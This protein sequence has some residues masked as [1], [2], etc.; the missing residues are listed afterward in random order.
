MPCLM[1][2]LRLGHPRL[3]ML[4]LIVALGSGCTAALPYRAHP[5]LPHRT[6]RIRTVGIV[7]PAISAY[8]E[9]AW[10]K[11]T[12]DDNRS[13]QAER[14]VQT[15][16]GDEMA[17]LNIP[18]VLI[19]GGD[20]DLDDMADLFSAVD[21]TMNLYGY[22]GST[23]GN[24]ESWIEAF[25]GK[26]RFP[27]YALGPAKEAMARHGVDAVWFV[28]GYNLFPTT[29]ARVKDAIETLVSLVPRYGPGFLN[30]GVRMKYE[31][32]AALVDREGTIL[33][34]GKINESIVGSQGAGDIDG[35]FR[36]RKDL[37][38]RESAR[39]YLKALLS[40]YGKAEAP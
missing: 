40:G 17:A 15:A 20:P 14:T 26:D 5:E 28:S 2:N 13:R 1:Q 27:E 32:R 34:Y 19:E 11:A 39:R 37:R 35:G 29:G 36:D 31:V 3:R 21:F 30:P 33:Y 18:F 7:P 22:L 38:D 9:Q 6:A 12:P 4:L 8:E 23:N 10:R 24:A 16:L 25:P